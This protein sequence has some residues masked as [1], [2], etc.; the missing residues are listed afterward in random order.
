MAK[1][2]P[3]QVYKENAVNTASQGELSVMLYNGCLKF[4]KLAKKDIADGDL[5]AK[6]THLIRAQDIIR[7]I[8]VT[9]NMDS[10]VSNDL[11]R[12][13]DYLYRQLIEANIHNNVAILEEVEGF[14]IELRD[15]WKEMIQLNRKQQ[16]A[17][18]GQA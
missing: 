11:M 8:M 17:E 16:F 7:E 14:V 2:N 9:S 1:N 12:L 4:I 6:N 10:K 15:L 18:S 13:Y 3:Y 5:T